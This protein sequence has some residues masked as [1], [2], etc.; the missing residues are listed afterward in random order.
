MSTFWAWRNAEELDLMG[1]EWPESD[2]VSMSETE[3]V[4][5]SKDEWDA[6]SYSRIYH[7]RF[8]HIF[9]LLPNPG[10][11]IQ[12]DPSEWDRYCHCESCLSINPP[13]PC[14]H[15]RIVEVKNLEEGK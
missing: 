14:D 8:Q 6:K 12:I 7:T 11:A 3:P 1:D 13:P 2:M 9:G 5:Y 15:A 4:K 10:Q